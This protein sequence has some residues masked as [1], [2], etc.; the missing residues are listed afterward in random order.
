[1][2]LKPEQQFSHFKIIRKLGEGG[3]GEVYLA[4]DQKLGRNVA[5]KILHSEFFDNPDRLERFKREARTAAQ[6]NHSNIM[7]IH[8]IGTAQDESGKELNYIVMEFIEGESLTSYLGSKTHQLKDLLRIAEKIAVGLAAA[9]SLSIVHRDIKT[10][11]IIIN[12][13]G[14]PKILDFGLA[15]PL[16]AAIE[17]KDDNGTESITGDLTGEGKILGTVSYMS[18]EQAR[19]DAVDSR[20][21]VFSFGILLYKMFS[22]V[23]PFEGG[24]RVS[25][26]AKILESKH[27]PIRRKNPA[28]PAELE[29]IIDKCLQKD[30]DDRYQNTRDLAIDLR[31][32]RRQ[33]ESGISDSDSTIEAL[34]LK[35]KKSTRSWLPLIGVGAVAIIAVVLILMSTRNRES[36][37]MVQN[38]PVFYGDALA[39]LSFEN[40]TNDTTLNW[41]ISGIPELISTGLSQSSISLISRSQIIASLDVP[42]MDP[43]II[44]DRKKVSEAALNLGA[45]K[46][47]SGSFYKSGNM[48]RI[49]ARLEEIGTGRILLGEKVVGE[50]IFLLSD[51]LTDKIAASL[52]IQE[53]FASNREVTSFVSSNK[54]AYKAYVNGLDKYNKGLFEESIDDFDKAISLD[55]TFA[56]PYMRIGMVYIF[57]NLQQQGA[58]Y[59]QMAQKHAD[60]LP[61]REKTLLDIFADIWIRQK[62]DDAYAKIQSY[63]KNYPEDW[64]GRFFYAVFLY[65]IAAQY[66]QALAQIDTLLMFNQRDRWGLELAAEI[67]AQMEN[68]DKAINYLNLIKQYFPESP[69]SYLSLSTQ[70]RKLRQF[71]K[72]LKEDAELL[73]MY[74]GNSDAANQA[75]RICIIQRDFDRA[76]DYVELIKKYHSDNPRLM[77]TY[78]GLI[79][80]LEVWKGNFLDA[81]DH[82][83][84][85][86][87]YAKA[88]QEKTLI[89]AG[90]N[91]LAN[92]Y[93]RI[94][95]PD[96]TLKYI[97][98]ARDYSTLFEDFNYI[99]TLMGV[100][101]ADC[102][103]LQE[104]YQTALEKFKAKFPADFWEVGELLGEILDGYCSADTTKIIDAY[105]TLI[106]KP[107]QNVSGNLYELGSLYVEFGQHDKG[108]EYL[109]RVTEGDLQSTN[110]LTYIKSLYYIGI[111][112]QELGNHSEARRRFQ[113]MLKYWSKPQ[114]ELKEIKD[115]RQRLQKLPS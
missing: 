44:P 10:D 30:P 103:R 55:S 108:I 86:I 43:S 46:I 9:H 26:I 21:D 6:I 33:Y 73:E 7:S 91:V 24:D 19:G 22:G 111:A 97:E 81:V 89:Y 11:N 95:M 105:E 50:D 92:H 110:P 61:L 28:L 84:K 54:D 40:K 36:Q 101:R 23:S 78:E 13:E 37:T 64:E 29:R 58:A 83:H 45:S 31:S 56:L 27:E 47:L 79:R 100:D 113:E 2:S 99:F 67:N 68:Y 4:E 12:S 41:M 38:Q 115:A 75:A 109:K 3:M 96:S 76:R 35:S 59:L 87:D 5:L 85:Y 8:D 53:M 94:G 90:Y 77:M 71:D 66:D 17:S 16:T 14:D 62:F 65:Q 20:S 102:P 88:T 1:M 49:D 15:K 63:V 82:L 80:D 72:A 48:L 107:Q 112:E 32:L 18:P 69:T 114:I 70:Y 93:L 60:K 42:L 52:N 34:K 74:P 51:S 104:I 25:T 98:I 57:E 39:I 106:Q